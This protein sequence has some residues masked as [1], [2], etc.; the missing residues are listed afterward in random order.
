MSRDIRE[1]DLVVIGAG[2]AGSAA[3]LFAAKRGLSVVQ[4]GGTG[5]IAYTSGYFDV[6]GAVPPRGPEGG[7]HLVEKP[8]QGLD[9][10]LASYPR[11]PYWLTSPG[12]IKA[13][14]AEWMDFLANRGLPYVAE[15]ETNVV[16]PSPAGTLKHT[17]ALPETMWPFVR[18]LKEKPACLLVDFHGLNGF[19]ARQVA[20]N[21]LPLWPGLRAERIHFPGHAGGEVFPENAARSLELPKHR[22]TLAE[23]VRPL[24]GDA[25]C[26]GLPAL[27]GMNGCGA[28]CADLEERLGVTVFE[29]P[30]MP[31]SVP[32]IRLREAVENG[33]P[34]LGVELYS[35][36]MVR[37]ER[38]ESSGL[39]FTIHGQSM[40]RR[41]RCRGVILASGRFLGGGLASTQTEVRETIFDL[42]VAQP[43]D[44]SGWHRLDYFD[45]RGHPVHQSGIEVDERFRPLGAGGKPVCPTLFAAGSILAHQDWMRMKCGAGV[46][47][48]TALGAVES[49]IAELGT[50]SGDLATVPAG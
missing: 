39:E 38:M 14:L 12:L 5:A 6:L 29:I 30:T 43:E 50:V 41:V 13:A 28:V 25:T 20:A 44:R 34:E 35:Q 26:L 9:E 1:C 2:L 24:L 21:L 22:E 37:L 47:L 11:H 8:F 23:A 45:P 42:P 31:P 19:S 10:L 15:T 4:A 48:A 18:L 36:Q 3:A 7:I 27:L 32:G 17:Y 40:E 49:L 46:A 16:A 33:L